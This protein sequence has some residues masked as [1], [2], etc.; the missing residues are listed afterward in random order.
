MADVRALL[1]AKREQRVSHPFAAY[2]SSG[3][4]RCS[5]CS[6]Q[7]KH[8]SAWEG[9]LGSKV[10]R[11]NVARLKEEENRREKRKAEE[12]ATTRAVNGAGGGMVVDESVDNASASKKRRVEGDMDV[13]GDEDDEPPAS[14][15]F[16]ANFFS[17]P[18]R[19]PPPRAAASDD[20]DEDGAGI[21]TGAT[22]TQAPTN[23]TLDA[24]WDAFSRTVLS[25]PKAPADADAYAHATVFAEPELITAQTDDG[26]P[27]SVLTKEPQ[28]EE[29]V[30]ETEDQIRKRKE[31]EEK[32]LIMDRIL[33]E[34]RAQEDADG[35]VVALKARL[36]YVKRKRAEA[37]AAKGKS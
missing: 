8:A 26:F 7:V 28:P 35:R 22:P 25:A 31:Q 15:G 4:L 11:T 20:E 32:E 18:S 14:S 30:E 9:H 3:Q 13:G 5:A 27:S 21:G 10:H 23:T 12:A 2:N 29:K 16:P 24:E 1:K 36:E 37:R 19:A 34:E 17:D 33:E 6:A